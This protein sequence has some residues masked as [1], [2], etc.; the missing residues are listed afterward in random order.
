[1]HGGDINRVYR[2]DL[3]LESLVIK[4]NRAVDFPQM[5]EKE[6]QG[7]NLLRE[8][9]SF[10]I[11]EVLGIGDLDD[12]SYLMLEYLPPS[13]E[14]KGFWRKFAENLIGLHQHQSA[15]FGLETDNYIGSL[16]QYNSS[17]TMDAVEFYIENRL[18][19]QIDLALQKGFDL[20]PVQSFYKNLASIIPQEKA[21][22]IHGDLWS[23]NYL[24]TSG[25][26]PVLIDPAVAYA[27]REMDLAMM[28]LFG[29]F[30]SEVFQHYHQLFPLPQQ[31][32]ER[33]ELWQLY[34]L[35][36]HLNLF[37]TSY[38]PSVNRII[39]KFS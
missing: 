14:K 25:D 10:K 21:S 7:L 4:L 32:E 12:I 15:I 26:I 5:F 3:S 34:Y 36:V 17:E 20:K 18:Q 31:W 19:P 23:G 11:P 16:P 33:M 22:L 35:L 38:L 9:N 6:A 29:G 8:T 2:L 37:G 24:C 13:S 39:S 27:S 1:M 28:Q 30:P